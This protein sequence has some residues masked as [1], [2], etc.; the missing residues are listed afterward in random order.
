M[1]HMTAIRWLKGAPQTPLQVLWRYRLFCGILV[2]SGLTTMASD[3]RMPVNHPLRD[4]GFLVIDA[5]S[6]SFIAEVAKFLDPD[7]ITKATSFLP[8]SLVIVNNTGRYVWGFTVI[9]TLPDVIAPAGKPWRFITSPSAKSSDRNRMMCPGCSYLITPVS[10]FHGAIDAAGTRRLQPFV[11]EGMERIIQLFE[12]EYLN[13]RFEASI[14][15]VIYEDGTLAGPDAAGN[16]S[17]IN[18]RIRADSD[19]LAA[20]Q[21]LRGEELRKALLLH[22]GNLLASG[23]EYSRHKTRTAQHILDSLDRRGEAATLEGLEELRKGKWFGES[24]NVRRE[25][26]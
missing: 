17:L 11:D 8:Y 1:E 9:Y 24:G 2:A 22:S 26:R 10:D 6:P 15:S 19:L 3:K 13:K 16:M 20:L 4:S 18:S 7:I 21:G 14:D 25:E 23:E 12:A 5:S